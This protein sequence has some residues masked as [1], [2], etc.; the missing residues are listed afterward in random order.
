MGKRIK[1]FIK[2]LFN[3]SYLFYLFNHFRGKIVSYKSAI[4][5]RKKTLK[6]IRQY[7]ALCLDTYDG[8]SQV[9]HPDC[10]Y[11]KGDLYLVCTPYPFGIEDYENP[12]LFF[13]NDLHNLLPYSKKPLQ[14]QGKIQKHHYLSDPCL[15]IDEGFL[16]CFYRET[17]YSSKEKQNSIWVINALDND[18][19][20][21]EVLTSKQDGLMSPIVLNDDSFF[22]LFYITRSNDGSIIKRCIFNRKF[23]IKEVLEDKIVDIPTDYFVWHFD[24]N[25]D[26]SN[27]YKC[28]LLLR[29]K[30]NR[31][32]FIL[33]YGTF[34]FKN[35][36]WK[37]GKLV[38]IPKKLIK[39]IKF[40]YKSC[41]I[42]KSDNILL[43]FV[44]KR[45][46]YFLAEIRGSNNE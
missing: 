36:V 5:F 12:S 18:C 41:F 30:A 22:Y 32:I 25:Y 1:L 6:K 11:Y 10:V 16:Y 42:P 40:C 19:L 43:S 13:G 14:T 39:H 9:T 34:D 23:E 8:S 38:E 2:N 4:R 44:D 45:N 33:H 20:P 27:L 3:F 15:L 7:D 24:I 35:G 37:V 46:R 26:D 17:F 28:L 31:D 29:S 21:K